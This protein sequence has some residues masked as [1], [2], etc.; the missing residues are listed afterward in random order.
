MMLGNFVKNLPSN[1]ISSLWMAEYTTH[2][3]HL[4]SRIKARLTHLTVESIRDGHMS[5]RNSSIERIVLLD[6]LQKS[7]TVVFLLLPMLGPFLFWAKIKAHRC[8]KYV[9]FSN[10]NSKGHGKIVDSLKSLS[11]FHHNIRGLRNK[12][13]EF[14]NSFVL[15][16]INPHILCLTEHHVEEQNLLNL[17]LSGFFP[18]L[19][20]LSP[21]P[22]ARSVYFY[23]RGS[24]L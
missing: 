12:S 14:I 13:N 15:D 21:K 22:T 8:L 1:F 2:G 7:G 6:F 9:K 10:L 11:I 19:Q 5:S 4:N 24:K 3:L 18:R 20:L 16:S 23:Q 17:T